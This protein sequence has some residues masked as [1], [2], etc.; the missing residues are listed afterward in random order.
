MQL[1]WTEVKVSE[2]QSVN[3]VHKSLWKNFSKK[4][5]QQ[6]KS[7]DIS[8]LSVLSKSKKVQIIV[9]QSVVKYGKT[10]P[11]LFVKGIYMIFLV[12]LYFGL[13]N[14]LTVSGLNSTH[15]HWFIFET[16]SD[17]SGKFQENRV[18]STCLW[19]IR[20]DDHKVHHSSAH[21]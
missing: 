14:F 19:L 16:F 17:I 2:K 9:P 5:L 20:Y 15:S 4:A 6:S 7:S 21:H 3:M 8:T 11:K 1:I 12:I 13:N 18:P 10:I